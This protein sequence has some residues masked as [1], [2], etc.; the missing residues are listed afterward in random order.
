MLMIA[1]CATRS[2]HVSSHVIFTPLFSPSFKTFTASKSAMAR[3]KAYA[4]KCTG[5]SAPTEAITIATGDQETRRKS[6]RSRSRR[7]TA[8]EASSQLEDTQATA[9]GSFAIIEE[10]REVYSDEDVDEE[11][12]EW[13]NL[14]VRP[15]FSLF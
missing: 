9:M 12:E 2:I 10:A 3:T 15:R 1:R 4:R 11:D 5:A 13:E 8:A 6:T 7:A 14:R